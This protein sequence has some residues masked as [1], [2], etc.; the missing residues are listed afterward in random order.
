MFWFDHAEN[1]TDVFME[2]D[3]DKS[4]VRLV[5]KMGWSWGKELEGVSGTQGNV[6]KRNGKK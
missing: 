3:I 5:K 6:V 2:G 4:V 1:K